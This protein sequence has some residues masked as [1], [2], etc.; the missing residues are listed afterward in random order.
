MNFHQQ[1]ASRR[2]S[3][4]FGNTPLR[5]QYL[6]SNKKFKTINYIEKIEEDI[7]IVTENFLLNY[8]N[9][10]RVLN[11]RNKYS[12]YLN[13][14]YIDL[15][16][17]IKE[18]DDFDLF[19]YFDNVIYNKNSL[20]EKKHL[21]QMKNNILLSILICAKE[22]QVI[23][24]NEIKKKGSINSIYN[25]N[26]I[27][28]IDNSNSNL[29]NNLKSNENTNT[30]IHNINNNKNL[31]NINDDN[32]KYNINI[33]IYNNNFNYNYNHNNFNINN[34]NNDYYNNINNN[35]NNNINNIFSSEKEEIFT[36][37][38][39]LDY[40]IEEIITSIIDENL[41][42]LIDINNNNS[43]NISPKTKRFKE[44]S[45]TLSINQNLNKKNLLSNNTIY[46]NNIDCDSDLEIYF[47]FEYDFEIEV[48]FLSLLDYKQSAITIYQKFSNYFKIFI[49]NLNLPS[50]DN[51]NNENNRLTF[52]DIILTTSEKTKFNQFNIPELIVIRK[53]LAN[54]AK[55]NF[56]TGINFF[57]K[58][59]E[60]NIF[61][62]EGRIWKEIG[63]NIN[64]KKVYE[65]WELYYSN[66]E[67]IRNTKLKSTIQIEFNQQLNKI[68]MKLNELNR[69]MNNDNNSNNKIDNNN[70]KNNNNNNNNN[71]NENEDDDNLRN[72]YLIKKNKL[73][74]KKN[75]I[76]KINKLY[77]VTC[78]KELLVIFFK[79]DLKE[80]VLYFL[81]QIKIHKKIPLEIFEICLQYDEDIC[82]NIMNDILTKDNVKE[83]YM[84][85]C[86]FKKY[87]TLGNLLCK[88][89]VCKNY[90]NIQPNKSNEKYMFLLY[91][92]MNKI[93][94]NEF[95]QALF[96]K[97]RFNEGD[98]LITMFKEDNNNN[99]INNI[100]NNDLINNNFHLNINGNS[101]NN[102]YNSNTNTY[103]N[104]L[105][106]HYYNSNISNNY[107]INNKG[108]R[109]SNYHN[110]IYESS[111]F[112]VNSHNLSSIFDN[113]NSSANKN[114]NYNIKYNPNN[115]LIKNKTILSDI[116]QPR[117]SLNINSPSLIK[118][119]NFFK[120]KIHNI[121]N[122]NIVINNLKSPNKNLLALPN[123]SIYAQLVN[124]KIN[125]H[126]Y[127]NKSIKSFSRELNNSKSNLLNISYFSPKRQKK[128]TNI[129][130][131]KNKSFNFLPTFKKFI[132]NI[133]NISTQKSNLELK[134]PSN[135]TKTVLNNNKK[136]SKNI[137]KNISN[138][139]S[140][141]DSN[142]DDIFSSIQSSKNNLNIQLI[143]IEHLCFGQYLYNC[144]SL[145]MSINLSAINP[146]YIERTCQYLLTYTTNSDSITKCSY[147]LLSL[148]LSAE[149]LIKIG[150]L[151]KKLQNKTNT[152]ANELLKLTLSIQKSMT[153]LDTLNY[154]L[155]RQFDN[156]GRNT[157]MICAI[158][159][160]D[161]LLGDKTVGDI[162]SKMWYGVGHEQSIFRFFRL[163][164]ILKANMNYEYFDDVIDKNY[165]IGQNIIYSFQFNYYIN[166]S[167]HRSNFELIYT[168][169]ICLSYQILIYFYV[170]LTKKKS[171]DKNKRKFNLYK[172]YMFIINSCAFL[173]LFSNIFHFI[174][175]KYTKRRI[176]INKYKFITE[177]IFFTSIFLIWIDFTDLVVDD[178]DIDTYTLI[179]GILY[180]LIIFSSWLRIINSLFLSNVFGS[181]LRIVFHITW[182]VFMFL[183]IVVCFTFCFAQCFTIFFKNSNNDFKIIYK[184][185]ITLFISSFGQINFDNFEHLTLLGYGFLI[186]FTV[187]SNLLL[188]NLIV[189]IINDLFNSLEEK[190]ES[191][192]RSI[193]IIVH[194]KI[195]WDDRYG[196][197]ILL[198]APL[199]LCSIF[200]IPILIII[201]QVCDNEKIIKKYNLIFSKIAYFFIAIFYFFGIFLTGIIIYFFAVIKTI[202]FIIYYN[203]KSFQNKTFF[204]K[205]LV[206]NLIPF[207][208][209]YYFIE[210]LIIY[211]KL[212]Y[213]MPIEKKNNEKKNKLTKDFILALRKVLKNLNINKKKK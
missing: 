106:Y 5:L 157:L 145:L 50:I 117:F 171:Y 164:R 41:I 98:K 124:R 84:Q 6:Y 95:N 201:S 134:D 51:N 105:N 45:Q 210:D 155:C 148:V 123:F 35:N 49:D 176:K 193:L 46:Y 67:M 206:I 21:L 152:V 94:K 40:I 91:K 172:I 116:I 44:I 64:K 13:K 97:K 31:N 141:I 102:N 99:N 200:F 149:Y 114:T 75:E 183:L 29:I 58:I 79:Y 93:K 186:T 174:F 77:F 25:G 23:E 16:L 62:S 14:S 2:S 81:Q 162:V 167:S 59:D 131:I 110:R 27:N 22:Q 9:Y 109:T 10:T 70:D 86:I 52:N 188:F 74:F 136:K 63:M 54:S 61:L 121:N 115:N 195:K 158:N 184:S 17:I 211:W 108:S 209:I 89:K 122:N 204:G 127:S 179:E 161:I 87:F 205:F 163:T 112:T 181:F 187:I 177:I 144:I 128:K 146:K 166:N 36:D 65:I 39:F 170:D 182:H 3:S 104:L 198:P 130:L 83:N 208:L 53:I 68:K 107:I 154:Y 147:P 212:V 118:E 101:I 173:N 88:F 7:S 142:I 42:D 132:N 137:N 143:L 43:N 28:N 213:K 197:L 37:L 156:N 120:N 34:N 82:I 85:I 12:K 202:I 160:F 203:T 19:E 48:Y 168:I 57:L 125:S 190:N 175:Y 151:N 38:S 159:E 135:N 119:K 24:I 194:E 90:L 8:P 139:K 180:S 126:H 153:N 18:F 33:T 169:I 111:K 103:N 11:F 133:K 71:N 196:L 60:Y 15:I 1:I 129:K 92:Y 69:K 66:I 4:N 20:N 178:E 189:G 72:N 140:S 30:I 73:L 150:K 165:N 191:Q 26:N 199:N 185:F 100:D 138:K 56:Y 207:K 96:M 47:T 80:L 32:N 76:E 78:L 192:S 55:R 113:I